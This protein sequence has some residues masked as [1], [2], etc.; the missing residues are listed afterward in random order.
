MKTYELTVNN[1]RMA[2]I[3]APSKTWAENYFKDKQ[4]PIGFYSG[5][6][7]EVREAM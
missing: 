1:E 3:K 5:R 7:I 2:S 6:Y 4:W